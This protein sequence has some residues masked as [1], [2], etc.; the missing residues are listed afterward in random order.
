[1][2]QTR[3]SDA[4]AAWGGL[5]RHRD[6]IA[7]GSP[8][9]GQQLGNALGG[10]GGKPGEDVGEPGGRVEGVELGSLVQ[11]VDRGGALTAIIGTVEQPVLAAEDKAADRPLGGVVI[12]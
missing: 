6:W 10:M 1:M 9:P 4:I 2:A 5:C 3:R 12:D 11:R 8:V 7:G